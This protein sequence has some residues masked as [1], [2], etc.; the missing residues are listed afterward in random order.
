M[1][2]LCMTYM[3]QDNDR[4]QVCKKLLCVQLLLTQIWPAAAHASRS[5]SCS[6]MIQQPPITYQEVHE[7]W[8]NSHAH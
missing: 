7:Q 3:I 5:S 2:P 8:A 4:G 6:H 1:A